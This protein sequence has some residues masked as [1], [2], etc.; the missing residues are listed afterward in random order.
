VPSEIQPAPP[1]LIRT[2][3]LAEVIALP[4]EGAELLLER[5][6]AGRAKTHLI[7]A[8]A[9]AFPALMGSPSESSISLALLPAVDA[10]CGSFEELHQGEGSVPPWWDEEVLAMGGADHRIDPV[11]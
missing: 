1:P 7:A 10:R 6:P 9:L 3:G 4:Q 2:R 5:L 8:L 11:R